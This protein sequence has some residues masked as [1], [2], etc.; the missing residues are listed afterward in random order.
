MKRNRIA[1]LIMALMLLCKS[2]SAAISPLLPWITAYNQYAEALYVPALS[3][4]M[5]Y[6]KDEEAGYYSFQLSG[7][8]FIDV[9]YSEENVLAG[10]EVLVPAGNVRA[11][12]IF[13]ACILAADSTLKRENI[14]PLFEEENVFHYRDDA[15]EYAYQTLGGWIIIFSKYPA[16]QDSAAFEVYSVIASE[17]YDVFF[18]SDD[19]ETGDGQEDTP[20]NKEDGD[21]EQPQEIPAPTPV[22]DPKIHKL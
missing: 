19:D 5:I 21:K 17:A 22:T 12:N 2:A 7:S 9:Y 20:D 18:N 3:M 4:E 8:T 13:T 10:I 1:A 6:E 16:T 11:E 14:A 15:G